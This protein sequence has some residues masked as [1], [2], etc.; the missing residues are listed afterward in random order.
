MRSILIWP[1][2]AP[3][4]VLLLAPCHSECVQSLSGP[5]QPRQKFCCWHRATANPFNP[6]LAHFSP[7]RSSAA[8]TVPQRMRSILIWPISAPPEVLLLAPC[9]SE[10]VQS[11]SGPFQP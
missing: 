9:H 7:A 11:L 3:P 5:F 2:S 8:G 1:I 4:E 6:Y 10:C